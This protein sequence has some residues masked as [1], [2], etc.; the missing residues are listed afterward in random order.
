MSCCCKKTYHFC[1]TVNACNPSQLSELFKD[2]PFGDYTLHLEF[3]N[4]VTEIEIKVEDNG[5]VIPDV[6]LNESYTYSCKL[7]DSEGARVNLTVDEVEYD[8]FTF[9]TSL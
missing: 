4:S 5:V 6:E 9:K 3:L 7:F 2:L 8:C 1:K